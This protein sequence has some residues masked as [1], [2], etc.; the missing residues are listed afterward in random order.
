MGKEC[1]INIGQLAAA[2]K[3]DKSTAV[4]NLVEKFFEYDIVV[5]ELDDALE[6]VLRAGWEGL[7][8]NWHEPAWKLSVAKAI[9][10]ARHHL[11]ELFELHC[12]IQN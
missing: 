6:D 11:Q 2:I 8:G 4:K 5:N 9:A 7:D 3:A 12:E 10:N 1:K